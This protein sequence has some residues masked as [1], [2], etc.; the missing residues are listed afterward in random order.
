MKICKKYKKYILYK[1]VYYYY[2]NFKSSQISLGKEEQKRSKTGFKYNSIPIFYDEGAFDLLVKGR[3][4]IFKHQ[5]GY[6]ISLDVDEANK[7]CFKSIEAK[8]N[9]EADFMER[10][11]LIKGERFQRVYSKLYTNTKGKI[12]A[13]FYELKGGRKKLI[14]D[15]TDWVGVTFTGKILF[16]ITGIFSAKKIKTTTLFA[17]EVLILKKEEEEE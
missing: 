6:S 15:P 13:S 5:K 8:I 9:K 10:L 4:R 3:L 14:E 12:S 2:Q 11:D 16:R 1:N 17:K 7:T